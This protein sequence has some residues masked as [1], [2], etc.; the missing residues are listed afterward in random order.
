MKPQVDMAQR[1]RLGAGLLQC[2]EAE[3]AARAAAMAPADRRRFSENI[4]WLVDYETAEAER[5]GTSCA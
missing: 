5:G 3:V 4:S 2:P 1:T